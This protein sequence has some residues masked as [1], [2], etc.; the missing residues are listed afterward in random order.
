MDMPWSEFSK[1][2]NTNK[3]RSSAS[4]S[5]TTSEAS[6]DSESTKEDFSLGNWDSMTG[7]QDS[8][9]RNTL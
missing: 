9:H 7:Y 3:R 2:L 6:T 5:S 4:A 8:E 1:L